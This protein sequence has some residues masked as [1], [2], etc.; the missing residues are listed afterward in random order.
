WLLSNR[1]NSLGNRAAFPVC[2]FQYQIQASSSSAV[3]DAVQSIVSI[4]NN[5]YRRFNV[6]IVVSALEIHTRTKYGYDFTKSA[7]QRIQHVW[8]W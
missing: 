4:V 6:H 8:I 7:Q 5:M 3:I 2:I 1:T